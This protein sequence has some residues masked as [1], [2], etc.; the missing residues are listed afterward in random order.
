MLQHPQ[1]EFLFTYISPRGEYVLNSQDFLS[2]FTED[3][4]ASREFAMYLNEILQYHL[5]EVV[6]S[7]VL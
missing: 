3:E 6:F 7:D 1:K 2:R 4:I 5:I